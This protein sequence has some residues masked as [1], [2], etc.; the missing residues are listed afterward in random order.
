MV[1]RLF[2]LCSILVAVSFLYHVPGVEA[3]AF[4]QIHSVRQKPAAAATIDTQAVDRK[5]KE[6][7]ET[8]QSDFWVQSEGLVIKVLKDDSDGSPHQRF[9]LRLS[10]GHSLLIAHNIDIAPRIQD[11]KA[12]DV[13]KFYGAYEWNNKGGVVHWTHHDPSGRKAGGWLEHNG[14]R[15]E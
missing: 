10:N 7:Y 13:I 12:G 8:A 4:Q 11:L 2:K 6:A 15:Y 5:I 3:G 9:L 1:K 14:R